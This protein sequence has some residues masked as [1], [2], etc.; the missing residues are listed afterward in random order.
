[1]KYKRMALAACA[2][3]LLLSATNLSAVLTDE[4][5]RYHQHLE[6]PAY[7]P[8]ADHGEDLLCSHL[9]LVLIDTGGE[10]I[11]GVP[12]RDGDG[13][14][15]N[16]TFTTTADGSMLLRASVS[17][18]DHAEGNN[19]PADTPTLQSVID[20]RVR[21]NSSRYFDKHSVKA[22]LFC[23]EIAGLFCRIAGLFC[24]DSRANLSLKPVCF[25]IA[26]S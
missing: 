19:H 20:I 26:I 7:T 22:K 3:L 1:M 6:R 17:V 24:H 18:V 23:P 12:I 2:L 9:P 4:H 8:C 15:S 5:P 13:S 25:G 21:G 16:D 11:P 10:A 14:R